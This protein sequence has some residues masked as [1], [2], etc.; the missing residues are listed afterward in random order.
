[1]MQNPYQWFQLCS[2]AVTKDAASIRPSDVRPSRRANQWR[3]SVLRRKTMNSGCAF[4]EQAHKRPSNEGPGRTFFV[5][6][7]TRQAH[8]RPLTQDGRSEI[9]SVSPLNVRSED[10][11]RTFEV[12][13]RTRHAHGRPLTQ[14]GRSEIDSV[15][16]LNVRSE[17]GRSRSHRTDVR[18]KL[19]VSEKDLCHFENTVC[20][21]KF[22][23]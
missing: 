23:K 15:S 20:L 6:E 4:A 19:S 16:P 21:R 12:N 17:D 7:H 10:G 2:N 11:R 1:M 5:N 18:G 8:G 14:D 9:D 3:S 13:Q 22:S